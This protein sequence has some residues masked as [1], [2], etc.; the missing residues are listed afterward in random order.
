MLLGALGLSLL[1]L[2]TVW[3]DGGDSPFRFG[4]LLRTGFTAGCVI[5]LLLTTAGQR[6]LD[7][8][9][10]LRMATIKLRRDL[11]VLTGRRRTAWRERLAAA[12]LPLGA[13]HA[14]DYAFFAW[15]V[16]YVDVAVAAVLYELWPLTLVFLTARLLG[17]RYAPL[18]WRRWLPLLTAFGGAGCAIYGRHGEFIL[19]AATGYGTGLILVGVATTTLAAFSFRWGADLNRELAAVAGSRGESRL[20]E[21]C[22]VMLAHAFGSTLALPLI[23]AA[24]VLDSSSSAQDSGGTALAL[25]GGLV[26]ALA[27]VCLR[28]A[29]VL[30]RNLGINAVAYGAPLFSLAWLYLASATDIAQPVWLLLGAA[31]VVAANLL[32]ARGDKRE[33][34]RQEQAADCPDA[35][36]TDKEI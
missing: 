10:L 14:F 31:L 4:L 22:C 19:T 35:G 13:L 36:H 23:G 33:Q 8:R 5:F 32:A 27:S 20:R 24:A 9:L 17:A 28:Q 16:G 11:A 26:M 2:A 34:P 18:T 21:L 25:A 15:A 1:P 30:T 12:A 6:G 29:N 7:R 3:A